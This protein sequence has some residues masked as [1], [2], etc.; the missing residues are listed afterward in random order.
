M[1][2]KS[3]DLLMFDLDG[4]ITDSIP[5]AIEAI[6]KMLQEL[7]FPY[8][9]KEEIH[10]HVG[11][12]EVPLVSGAIGSDNPELIKKAMDS[13]F[14]HYLEEKIYSIKLYPNMKETLDFFREKTKVII[15]NKKH[16]F[17]KIILENNNILDHFK[18][19]Y[20]GDNSPCLKP[21]PCTIN[22][23]LEEYKIEKEKA[24]FIGDMTIDIETGKNAKVPTCAV[25]YGF[26]PKEKLKKSN[27]DFLI[28]DI[29][30]LKN[31]IY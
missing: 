14:K 12:G 16:S 7:K 18:E 25:A 19:I 6:Q 9:S 10:T 17:I 5:G 28:D 3:I 21:D 15:S 1:P 8:K 27:P 11:F 29:S 22:K 2:K 26:D 4:T 24:L 13:Y 31:L 23:I 30:E 20:G